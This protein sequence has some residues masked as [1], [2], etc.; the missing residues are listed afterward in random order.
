MT[1]GFQEFF[2]LRHRSSLI[3]KKK[4][5]FLLSAVRSY[6]P[7][8]VLISLFNVIHELTQLIYWPRALDGWYSAPINKAACPGTATL[9]HN[10]S[11]YWDTSCGI[12]RSRQCISNEDRNA[13]TSRQCYFCSA[14]NVKLTY[15]V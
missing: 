14:P 5:P 4:F 3:S 9:A 2:P 13:S 10:S 11:N 12:Y 8:N 6:G 15:R 1:S 7:Q